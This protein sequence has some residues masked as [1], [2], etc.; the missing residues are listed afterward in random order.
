MDK[1]ALVQARLAKKKNKPK[2]IRSCV[3]GF[4]GEKA[5]PGKKRKSNFTNDLCDVSN[6]GAKRLRYDANVKQK[7]DKMTKQK[8]GKNK[9][10]D[11]P[12]F[13]KKGNKNAGKV[14]GKPQAKKSNKHG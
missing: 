7:Q 13:N 2:K 8:F 3:D 14:F 12:K 6:K 11:A 4:Q 1:V 5:T 10:R 9:S